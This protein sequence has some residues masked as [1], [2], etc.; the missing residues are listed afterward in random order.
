MHLKA[1]EPKNSCQKGGILS[2]S[3]L[4]VSTRSNSN[5]CNELKNYYQDL[6]D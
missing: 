6:V 2:Y 5:Y 3:I 4:R 1:Q